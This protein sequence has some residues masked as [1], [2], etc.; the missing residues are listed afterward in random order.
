[1]DVARPR[2]H[3][4]FAALYYRMTAPLEQRVLGER[5]AGLLADLT[6]TVLDVGAETGANLPHLRSASR[7]VAAEPDPAMRRRMAAKLAGAPVP[8]E[9][10]SAVAEALQQPDA[11]TGFAWP[12]GEALRVLDCLAPDVRVINLETSITRSR[13]FAPGKAV[14]YRMS[15]GNLP[16]LAAARPDA[17]ALAN[18]HAFD[19]G[20]QGLQDTLDALSGAGLRAVGA[21]RDAG[22]GR[23]AAGSRSARLNAP[24]SRIWARRYDNR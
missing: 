20:R 13:A 19:F 17:C 10:T 4:V 5:R 1:M 14:H 18:N 2:E 8:A 24:N 16:C 7:V 22:Q 3:R 9:I 6:G 23:F 21:G 15:P 11:S 12:W